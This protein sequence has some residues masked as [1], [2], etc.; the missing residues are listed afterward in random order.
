MQQFP[1]VLARF[2]PGILGDED[3]DQQREQST[4]YRIDAAG[5]RPPGGRRQ[6][7]H[8]ERLKPQLRG[9]DVAAVQETRQQDGGEEHDG[10]H[11]DV[12]TQPVQEQV[13]HSNADGAA[14]AHLNHPA[15]PGLPRE[16]QRDQR[17]RRREKGTRM[18]QYVLG[19]GISPHGAPGHLDGGDQRVAAPDQAGADAA[20]QETPAC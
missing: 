6:Q 12:A 2:P 18:P 3:G 8:Q 5:E 4:H 7:H 11:P 19:E 10:S 16:A 13:A 1:D 15:Q 9:E 20:A 14:Q 17:R